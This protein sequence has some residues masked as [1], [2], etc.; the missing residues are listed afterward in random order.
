MGKSR[1][2]HGR[3][4]ADAPARDGGD[5]L[6][7]ELPQLISTTTAADHQG[8][9]A[10]FL[11]RQLQ[12]PALRE[13]ECGEFRHHRAKADTAQRFLHRPQRI[14]VAPYA[15]EQQS[16]RIDPLRRQGAGIEVA[17]P[18]DPQEAATPLV[19]LPAADEMGD[20]SRRK[21]RFLEI[22]AVAGKLMQGPGCETAARQ[23]RIN[24]GKS[25]AEGA[26]GMYGPTVGCL[27]QQ[28]DLPPQ[29]S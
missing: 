11:R 2:S 13:V 6:G 26:T 7:S 28:G 9:H 19:A 27:F 10:A 29:G 18:G 25:P 16:I 8:R 5:R 3:C 21:A 1:H 17:L 4:C 12:A 14:L 24:G 20:G 15:Q 22:R 23:M